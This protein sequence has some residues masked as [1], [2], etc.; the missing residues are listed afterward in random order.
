MR[1]REGLPK[2]KDPR[3]AMKSSAP[4]SDV[5]FAVHL[6][7][8]LLREHRYAADWWTLGILVYECFTGTT[9]FVAPMNP[10]ETYRKILKCAVAG[11]PHSAHTR[12][13]L[14]CAR[15]NAVCAN[16]MVPPAYYTVRHLKV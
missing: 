2:A 12:S 5:S 15:T 13:C 8:S 6:P 14:Q 16:S 4:S 3:A 7:F 1:E 11:L 9:P 10:M